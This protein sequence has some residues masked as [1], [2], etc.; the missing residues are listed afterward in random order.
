LFFFPLV[1]I[2]VDRRRRRARF[3]RTRR[4]AKHNQTITQ[5]DLEMKTMNIALVE[6]Q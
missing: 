6:P 5:I 2:F 1:V 4:N 3:N